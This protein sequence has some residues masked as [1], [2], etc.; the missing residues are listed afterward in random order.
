MPKFWPKKSFSSYFLALKVFFFFGKLVN[1]FPSYPIFPPIFGPKKSF[2]FLSS[3]PACFLAQKVFFFFKIG[4]FLDLIFK[5]S[6][7]PACFFGPK[8]P[9]F[10]KIGQ[11]LDLILTFFP[12][13]WPKK[14]FFF[15]IKSSPSL[16][17]LNW[18]TFVPYTLF[19]FSKFWH[20][21]SF[22]FFC[23]ILASCYA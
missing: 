23:F 21:K 10:F 1:F 4:Q 2:F 7:A 11:F 17:F 12:N 22:F 19:F 9:F 20:K 15:L 6:S 18:S 13:F 3:A 8:S 16:F 5:L 14:S